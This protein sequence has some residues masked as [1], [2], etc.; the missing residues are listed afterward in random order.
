MKKINVM[1]ISLLLLVIPLAAQEVV[2]PAGHYFEGENMS[3]S[4]TLGELAVETLYGESIVLTQ[5]FQQSVLL[6]TSL[7]ELEGADIAVSVFPNPTSNVLT[8]S[9]NKGDLQ[10]L[11]YHIYDL[12]GVLLS[13]GEIKNIEET[14][15]FREYM[16]GVYVLSVIKNNKPVHTFRI[17][18]QQ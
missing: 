9:V 16:T 4:F 15:S 1:F 13:T 12:S 3:I 2:A 17:V 10:S 6:I 18:K 8:V 14:I 7:E 11:S 5:G